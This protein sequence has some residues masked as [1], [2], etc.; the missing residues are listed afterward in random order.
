MTFLISLVLAAL[1]VR[2]CAKSLKAHPVPY[3][4]AAVIIAAP[5]PDTAPAPEMETPEPTPTP[6]Q[7][8]D[9]PAQPEETPAP[10]PEATPTPTP[11]PEPVRVYQNG[12]FSGSG[13]GFSGPITVSVTLQ[14]DVITGIS[15]VSA[16]DDDAFLSEAKGVIS[17]MLSAQSA[18]VDTVSGATYSS[19]GIIA[20]LEDRMIWL[21]AA[22]DFTV[23]VIR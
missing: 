20:G 12:T 9:A 6:V 17:R 10:T 8:S 11:T 23:E 3:D 22:V 18:N 13:E 14:D 2:F 16:L 15:V 1:L 7:E 21:D 4:L 19:Q 5:A